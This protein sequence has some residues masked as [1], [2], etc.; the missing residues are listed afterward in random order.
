MGRGN[1]KLARTVFAIGVLAAGQ[2][3][4]MTGTFA[5]QFVMEGFLRWK[6]PIWRR[7]VITRSL[8]LGPALLVALLTS[9]SPNLNNKINEW[10]NVLQSVQLPFALLPF[11]SFTSDADI[12]GAEF[13]MG[14]CCQVFCWVLAL[15]IICLN[16]YLVCAEFVGSSG[17]MW[18]AVAIFFV[19]Y[20]SFIFTIIM[21][22][23][24]RLGSSIVGYSRQ[25]ACDLGGTEPPAVKLGTT[26]DDPVRHGA[27]AM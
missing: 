24:R 14:C 5:G 2:A 1:G 8:S 18:T 23:L 11:L 15:L 20:G 25:A 27:N 10:I 21:R 9:S 4:T 26:V 3:S 22:D 12:M 7:T 17:R 16:I 19:L 13:A 6:I